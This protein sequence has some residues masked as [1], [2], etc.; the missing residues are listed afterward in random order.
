MRR[1]LFV[2]ARALAL[3]ATVLPGRAAGGE[4]RGPRFALTGGSA[5]STSTESSAGWS[6]RDVGQ[7]DRMGVMAEDAVEDE[8]GEE[9]DDVEQVED[10]E[11]LMTLRLSADDCVVVALL[12]LLLLFTPLAACG[13][14]ASPMPVTAVPLSRAAAAA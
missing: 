3:G 7:D 10:D 14:G 9:E 12:L 6:R 13:C 2:G 8:G 1:L 4:E 5:M 11:T